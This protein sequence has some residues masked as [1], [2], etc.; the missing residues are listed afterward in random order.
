MIQAVNIAKQMPGVPV[1]LIWTREEDM[2][3][4]RYHPITQAKMV[5]AF[6]ENRTAM[7]RVLASMALAVQQEARA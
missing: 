6:D 4:G 2:T 1:K 7:V 3:H 5:G